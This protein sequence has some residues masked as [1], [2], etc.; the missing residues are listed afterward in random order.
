M[1]IRWMGKYYDALLHLSPSQA[2][3]G[4]VLPAWLTFTVRGNFAPSDL[5]RTVLFLY[6]TYLSQLHLSFSTYYT[7]LYTLDCL[8]IHVSHRHACL[9]S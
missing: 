6:P 2:V 5:Y 8:L 9:R 7:L 4:R 3:C 1:E